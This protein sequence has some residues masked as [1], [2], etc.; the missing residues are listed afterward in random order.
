MQLGAGRA[1]K[2]DTVDPAAGIMLAA[3]AGQQV[4]KGDL[5]ATL[6]TNKQNDESDWVKCFQESVSYGD[7]ATSAN[8]VLEDRLAVVGQSA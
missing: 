7:H 1:T 2:E 6:Y 4:R 3:K 8:V 5:L